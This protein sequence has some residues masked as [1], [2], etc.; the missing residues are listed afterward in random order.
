MT[1]TRIFIYSVFHPWLKLDSLRFVSIVSWLP[2]AVSVRY[3]FAH[4][5]SKPL[6]QDTCHDP[7]RH[8]RHV[9]RRLVFSQIPLLDGTA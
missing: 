9:S 7:R 1:K 4:P 2:P 8:R 3:D 5:M 6:A